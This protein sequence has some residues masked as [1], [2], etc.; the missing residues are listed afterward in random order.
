MVFIFISGSQPTEIATNMPV[1][2]VPISSP[3]TP[4]SAVR[5]PFTT[6]EVDY[7]RDKLSA[8]EYGASGRGEAR[9]SSLRGRGQ[10]SFQNVEREASAERGPRGRKPLA[11]SSRDD[12][13]SLS[14]GRS[15]I[16]STSARDGVERRGV[17]HRL[18]AERQVRDEQL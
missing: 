9:P 4:F 11:A 8:G 12:R 5:Q 16:P 3:P 10:S 17:R 13:R 1:P 15:A 14:T 7:S 2:H 6:P 18:A